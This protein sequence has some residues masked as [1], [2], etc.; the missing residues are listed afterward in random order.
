MNVRRVNGSLWTL[1]VLLVAGAVVCAGLGLM[2]PVEVS[3]DSKQT[4][5]RGSAT[6]QASPDS[7]MGLETFESIW[8]L[9]LRKPLTDAPLA[10]QATTN[11]AASGAAAGPFVLLGT[12]GDSLAMVRTGKG[13]IEVKG[14]GD[15]ANGAKIVAI[16]P[17][18]VDVEVGGT[19]MTVSKAPQGS[20]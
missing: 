14:I 19:R 6:S 12:I 4:G 10:A 1:T 20:K 16:R 18:Q 13:L 15:Q 17:S 7:Q 3:E 9:N 11:D 2:T 5:R 8:A